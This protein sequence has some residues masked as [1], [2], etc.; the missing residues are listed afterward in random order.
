MDERRLYEVGVAGSA[1]TA[2]EDPAA[3]ARRLARLRWLFAI[4]LGANAAT[5]SLAGIALVVGGRDWGAAFGILALATAPLLL[6]PGIV[7]GAARLAAR[8]RHARRP[9]DFPTG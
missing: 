4:G 6:L 2:R 9:E 3:K 7:E 5:W 1:W 8:R